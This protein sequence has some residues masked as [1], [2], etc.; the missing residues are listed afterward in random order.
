M[1]WANSPWIEGNLRITR[2]ALDEL[3]R[4]AV[5][6]YLVD[7]EACGYL[8]GPASDPLLCDRAA[9]IENLAKVLHERD[10]V[11]FFH[12][13]R[14]FFAFH[15]RTFEGA[16]RRGYAEGSPVKV[17]YHSHLDAEAYLSGTDQA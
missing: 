13:A 15:A 9:A 1:D 5:A 16:L 8:A 11:A 14:T 6:G 4:E 7:Q 3:E 10:P 17:L 12:T 2:A